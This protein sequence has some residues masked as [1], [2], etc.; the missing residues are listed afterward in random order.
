ML[1]QIAADNNILVGGELFADSLGDAESEGST[2][3]NML[4][5]NT[6]IISSAL[7]QTSIAELRIDQDGDQTYLYWILAGVLLLIMGIVF[8]KMNV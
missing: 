4:K 3:Y 2:Y 6:D 7:T 1:K 5:H 8:N